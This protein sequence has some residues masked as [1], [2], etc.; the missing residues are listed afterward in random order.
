MCAC[1]VVA[2]S[3]VFDFFPPAITAA[4]EITSELGRNREKIGEVHDKVRIF[5]KKKKNGVCDDRYLEPLHT[6][7]GL[8]CF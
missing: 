5:E 2:H 6:P 7:S 3:A 8:R 4:M 1:V